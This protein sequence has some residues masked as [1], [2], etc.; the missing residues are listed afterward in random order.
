VPGATSDNVSDLAWLAHARMLRARAAGDLGEASALAEECLGYVLAAAGIDDDF[1]HLWPPMV[2]AALEAGDV[3]QAERFL[4]PVQ[5]AA[6]GTVPDSVAA[7]LPL[8]RGSMRAVRGDDPALVEA[9]LR[10]SIAQLDTFGAVAFRARAEEQ[11]AGHLVA[12]GRTAEADE[13]FERARATYVGIGAHGW[14][15][16]LDAARAVSVAA[17]D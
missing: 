4:A 5:E 14:L 17:R 9:D 16:S 12:Q 11:L 1:M 6:P 7:L 3:A 8:L 2:R 13:L 15:A 10:S